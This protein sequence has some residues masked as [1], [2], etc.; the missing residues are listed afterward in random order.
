ME[1]RKRVQGAEHPD[2]LASMGNLASIY[3]NQ[4]QWKEAEDLEL[5]VIEIKKAIER[6][7]GP[8]IIGD[9]DEEEH[10]RCGAS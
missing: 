5:L 3:S 2:T 6:G 9:G 8:G 7:R 10:S 4:G 1:V